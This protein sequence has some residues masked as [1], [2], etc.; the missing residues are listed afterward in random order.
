MRKLREGAKS[1]RPNTELRT[2]HPRDSAEWK[3]LYKRRWSAERTISTL[4]E[5]LRLRD[6]HYRGLPKVELHSLLA[7]ITLQAKA[8]VQAK[9]GGPIREAVRKVAQSGVDRAQSG[10]LHI[11]GVF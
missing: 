10:D 9:D 7:V 4:K 8:L 11:F 2:D 1:R 3:R 5:T 6:H